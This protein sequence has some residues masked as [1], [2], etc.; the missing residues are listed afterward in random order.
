VGGKRCIAHPQQLTKHS[1]GDHS[2]VAV[3]RGDGGRG[4]SNDCRF[5]YKSAGGACCRIGAEV[6]GRGFSMSGESEDAVP[7]G[8]IGRLQLQRSGGGGDEQGQ[9][10]FL[11]DLVG[12]K[13]FREGPA[14]RGGKRV[15]FGGKPTS[16]QTTS[17]KRLFL[18]TGGR[19][20]PA[21]TCR[22]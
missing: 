18:R 20:G 16:N 22:G 4:R 15:E 8:N 1:G 12:R 2:T 17:S 5:S 14:G 6:G 19:M 10:Y 21:A 7:P 9:G 3:G 11:G 13:E